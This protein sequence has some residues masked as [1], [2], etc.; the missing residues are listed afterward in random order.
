M[1][2]L[3]QALARLRA[4]FRKAPLDRDMEAEM[5]SHLA[6]AIEENLQRGLSPQEAGRQALV[7][8][9]GV[10]QS[11][12][13][14][15]EARGLPALDV[16]IQDLRYTFR[17][18]RRDRGFASVAVLIL[19]LG[20]G[21]NIAVFSVVSTILLRPLPFRD[22]QR[23]VWMASERGV[24]GL[25]AVTY[26]VAAYEEFQRHNRSFQDVTGYDPFFGDSDF[27][28]LTGRGEPQE[29]SGVRVAENFLPTLGVQPALGRL[30]TPE[31]C[32]KGGRLA[33]LLG[34]SFWQRQFA[35]DPA[36]VGQALVLNNRPFTVVGVLRH[37]SISAPSSPWSE[38][39]YRRPGY[40]G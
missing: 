17:T 14:H 29:L 24:G 22:P 4:F 38:D 30:F 34:H 6:F 39:G 12:E 33:V 9:G 20:I 32:R 18:L 28:K 3:R 40:H 10:A 35:A 15:R 2:A 11:K 36:I 1:D 26:T 25:S 8:F 27:T 7:R 23:L 37:P 21:A 5:A 19:A 13:Q 31:E 16:L